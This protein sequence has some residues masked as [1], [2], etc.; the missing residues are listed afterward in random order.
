[1]SDR[2]KL[3]KISAPKVYARF[4]RTETADVA[5]EL[6][7]GRTPTREELTRMLHHYLTC[8]GPVSE[9]AEGALDDVLEEVMRFVRPRIENEWCGGPIMATLYEWNGGRK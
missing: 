9:R 1:M 2:S 6:A 3:A 8:T 4:R 7:L 5:A